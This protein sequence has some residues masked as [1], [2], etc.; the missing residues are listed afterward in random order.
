VPAPTTVATANVLYTLGTDDA[1]T[2]LRQVLALE[3]DLVGLQEWLP[4][5][6]GLLRETGR[7]GAVPGRRVRRQDGYLWNLP[8]VGGCAVGARADR[9]ELL[10]C[11]ARLLSPPGRADHED[12][13]LGLEPPRVATVAV[14]ADRRL[15]R[16]VALVDYH[17]APGVQRRGSYRADRPRLVARHRREVRRLEEIVAELLALGHVVHA[18]GD[19]NFDGLRLAG[20]TSAWEGH[21]DAP[22]TL[23][24][25]RRVDDVHGPGLAESVRLL[26][27]PSDHRAVVAR[28]P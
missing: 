2:A 24:P 19:S 20:L 9:F 12:R 11:R 26:E 22:G 15:D 8:V 1:R 28:R 18:V 3:P 21:E 14:Y 27:T 4:T 17:L 16:T 7:V 10:G 5:R 6:L 13:F 23:G 25:V